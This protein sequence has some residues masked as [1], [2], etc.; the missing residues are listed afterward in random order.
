[1]AGTVI[2]YDFIQGV[3]VSNVVPSTVSTTAIALNSSRN[4]ATTTRVTYMGKYLLFLPSPQL[5]F[6]SPKQ[7]VSSTFN[8]RLEC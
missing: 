8:N 3:I 2:I 4:I 5:T 7:E 6:P 1:M